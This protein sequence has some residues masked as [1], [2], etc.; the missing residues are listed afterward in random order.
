[1]TARR[2][3]AL[4]MALMTIAALS[5]LVLSFVYEAHQQ[6]GINLYVR[7]RDRVLRLVDAGQAIA[8]IVMLKYGDAPEW[9]KGQDVAKMLDEDRWILEKQDLKSSGRCKIGP[10]LLDEAKDESGGY[11]NPS[12]VTIEISPANDDK[13]NINTLWKGAGDDKY[14]ERW[15]MIF[16]DHGIP[17]KLMTNTDEGEIN[18]WNVLIASWDDWRD[19]DDV[20][21]SINNSECGAETSWYEKWER[22][23]HLDGDDCREYMRRP[24]NGPIPDVHELENIRGFREHPAVLTGG[25][26]NPWERAED[27]ITVRGILDV[28]CADGPAKINVNTCRNPSV[29]ITVPGIY[30]EPEPDYIGEALAE[31]REPAERIIAGLFKEPEGD[32]DDTRNW[33]PY[34]EWADLTAR[35]EKSEEINPV[36]G[37]YIDYRSEQFRVRII[38]ESMGMKHVVEAKCYVKDGKVRYYEWCENPVESPESGAAR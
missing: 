18:L 28:L 3:S 15:W 2:G 31:A 34:K 23:H 12:T 17:E 36:A 25:V 35:V 9:S 1:M 7:E 37:N 38:G 10:L 16:G 29:L 30:E 27:Q 21:S 24:R 11:A 20:P 4:I 33:W 8:E 5:A 32:F 14:V 13:I 22:D 19:E 6:S 26:I